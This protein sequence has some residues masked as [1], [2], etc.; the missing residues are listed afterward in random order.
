DIEF[1]TASDPLKVLRTQ[2]YNPMF[3]LNNLLIYFNSR[4]LVI[5]KEGSVDVDMMFSQFYVSNDY[6]PPFWKNQFQRTPTYVLH[7]EQT[8]TVSNL[9]SS[10]KAQLIPFSFRMPSS[11]YQVIALLDARLMKE[12]FYGIEDNRQFMILQED[13][14]LLYSSPGKLSAS[15]IPAFI[16]GNDYGLSGDYYFFFEKNE[17]SLLTYVTAVPYYNIASKVKNA[18]WTLVLVFAVSII[19]GLLTS[20]FLSRKLNQPVKQMVNSIL[21]RDPVKLESTI[22]EFDLIH[23]N[24]RELMNEKDAVHQELLD[25]RS[26]LTSFGYINKLKAITSDINDWKDIAE[27]DEPFLIVLFQLHFKVRS[28]KDSE[29]KTDRMAY[30]IQEYIKVLFSEHFPTS[31]TFQVENNQILSLICGN[32]LTEELDRALTILKTILDRDKA[33][34]LVTIAISSAYEHSSQFNEAYREVLNMAQLARPLDESQVIRERSSIPTQL[35]FTVP[36]EQELYANLQEGNHLNCI[37]FMNRMLS[38]FDKKGVSVQ[39]LRQLAEGVIARVVKLLEPYGID[40]NSSIY[41]QQQLALME[42]CYTLDQF[43]QFY[44]EL[45]QA[46]A[47]IIRSKKDEQDPTISF[48]MSYIENRFA[49]DLSLDQ[50]ADKLN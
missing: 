44:M 11:N 26:L 25:K 4:S 20:V 49:D 46:S 43:R 48:V 7:P 24:I 42:E 32:D 14:S 5:E 3:Y 35:V 41:Q 37:T 16:D 10:V 13:G 15:D 45:F 17:G 28:L 39:Q 38:Q 36:Q 12:A 1:W 9:N 23:Q 50:L 31:Q 33:Y 47:A 2:A 29:M 22:H 21:R 27:M 6:P 30:F 8:F 34:F 40:V 18:S 19:I